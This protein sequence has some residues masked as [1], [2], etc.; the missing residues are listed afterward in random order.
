MKI[1]PFSGN[2]RTILE[3]KRKKIDPKI[4][5]EE[6]K[7]ACLLLCF[8]LVNWWFVFQPF[9]LCILPSQCAIG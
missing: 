7:F 3:K 6:I 9:A 1:R 8:F 5:V 4:S 2:R